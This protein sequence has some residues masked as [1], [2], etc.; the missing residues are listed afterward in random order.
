V[1][2]TLLVKAAGMELLTL[3]FGHPWSFPVRTVLRRKPLLGR[4]ATARTGR[5]APVVLHDNLA[6]DSFHQIVDEDRPSEV[7]LRIIDKLQLF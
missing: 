4:G 5:E 3:L 2:T 6:V 1:T 7:H